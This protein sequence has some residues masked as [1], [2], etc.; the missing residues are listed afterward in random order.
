MYNIGE[1]GTNLKSMDKHI[2]RRQGNILNLFSAN[3]INDDTLQKMKTRKV[4]VSS[5]RTS[6]S[7]ASHSTHADTMVFGGTGTVGGFVNLT[8]GASFS[9]ADLVVNSIATSGF[10]N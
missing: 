9:A 6:I 4:K 2:K 8:S 5:S 7:K 3:V 1:G 10:R